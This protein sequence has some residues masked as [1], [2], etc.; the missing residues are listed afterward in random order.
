MKNRLPA[1]KND[2]IVVLVVVK[3]VVAILQHTYHYIG[4]NDMYVQGTWLHPAM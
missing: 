3:V 1:I 2:S 4:Y